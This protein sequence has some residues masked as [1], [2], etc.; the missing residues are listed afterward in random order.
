MKPV[1]IIM[2]SQTDFKILKESAEILKE[3]KIP[4]HV[5]VVSAHRT[6][7]KMV[8]FAKEAA[9]KYSVIIAGAGGAA[10]LPGMVASLTTL[11]VIGVPVLIGKIKGI[12]ALLSIAQMPGGVPVATVGIDSAKN[13]GLLAARILGISDRK[14]QNLL[15]KYQR[16]Q[17]QKVKLMNR[18]IRGL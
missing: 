11:P 1:A 17:I 6:P 15:E 3:F 2:G 7:E 10:H 8:S 12:D 18:S 16:T 5:E 9:D 13:A 4:T 14:I